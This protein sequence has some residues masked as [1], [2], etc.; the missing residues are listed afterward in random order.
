M[1]HVARAESV[2]LRGDPVARGERL[3]AFRQLERVLMPLEDPV[4][5]LPDAQQ[6]IVGGRRERA[7][8]LEPDLLHLGPPDRRIH[9][10]REHLRAQADPEEGHRRDRSPRG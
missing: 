9:R 5:V 7:D 3:G 4:A 2:R 6:R 10:P 8:R 1:A